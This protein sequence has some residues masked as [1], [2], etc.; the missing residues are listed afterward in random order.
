M[1]TIN[2]LGAT[3]TGTPTHREVADAIA[4]CARAYAVVRVFDEAL[5]AELLAK[6]PETVITRHAAEEYE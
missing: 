3:V 5:A 6:L 2:G 1:S 4:A